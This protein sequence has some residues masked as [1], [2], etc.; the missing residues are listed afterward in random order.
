[1]DTGNIALTNIR[2]KWSEGL[3]DEIQLDTRNKAFKNAKHT[4]LL[5]INILSYSNY[6]IGK[7]SITDY[8]IKWVYL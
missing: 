2:F 3:N 6:F 5:H 7:L 1:M 4:L 8:Y